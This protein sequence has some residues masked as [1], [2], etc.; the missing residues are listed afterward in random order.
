MYAEKG[1]NA[2]LRYES[3]TGVFVLSHSLC[4]ALKGWVMRISLM[5]AWNWFRTTGALWLKYTGK[6]KSIL[7]RLIPNIAW[8][9][10][11]VSTNY[12]V[13]SQSTEFKEFLSIAGC[14]L[15][16]AA[17]LISKLNIFQHLKF[18]WECEMWRKY[19]KK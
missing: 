5:V 6:F 10:K 12:L 18:N 7:V 11:L 19:W 4:E 15:V 8:C 1:S 17:L 2:N 13:F 9:P 3:I 14:W 16:T